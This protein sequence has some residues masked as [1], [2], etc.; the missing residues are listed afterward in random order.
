MNPSTA[1]SR[2]LVDELVRHGVAEAVVAPGSRSAPLAI[3]LADAA[4]RGRLRLHVRIDERSAAFTA[5]GLAKGAGVP[6]VVV[7]TSGTAVANMH[8]AVLE[9][10]HS[11][12]PL[13]ALTADRPAELRGAGANQTTDQVGVFGE[14]VRMFTDVPAAEQRSGQVA[15]WRSTV[16]RAVIAACGAVSGDPGP[17]HLNVCLREPLVPDDVRDAW[18]EAL[19]GRADGRPWTVVTG[20]RE[21]AGGSV[22]A[23]ARTV[24][25]IG[26]APAGVVDAA[27]ALGEQQRWPVVAEPQSRRLP[28]GVACGPLVVAAADWLDRHRPDRVLVVGRPTLSRP[29]AQ[30]VSGGVAPVDVVTTNPRWADA[31]G[32]A[33]TVYT[34]ADL[35]APEPS[36]SG[37]AKLLT[38]WTAA[39]E[40]AQA[41]V[42]RVLDESATGAQLP[43][44]LSAVRSCLRAVPSDALL[45][46]SSSSVVR[47][48]N[49][50]AERLP[51][52]VLTNRGVGGI[53]G[54][55]STAMG[56]AL[57]RG[58]GPAY[59]VMGDLA[60]LHDATGL[61]LGPDEARPDLCI[62]V[63]NDDGGGIFALLEQGAPRHA[64]T[65]E[66]VFG[67]PHGVDVEAL[68]AATHT[69]YQLAELDKLD[70]ALAPEPGLRVVEIRVDRRSHRE[71]HARLHEAVAA[72][73]TGSLPAASCR[74]A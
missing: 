45:F 36:G 6:A 1:L 37:D 52:T 54:T 25:V 5:L 30:L 66:R 11:G 20:R 38:A 64:A 72:A 70:A 59:A 40:R 32:G 48:A 16:S 19:D 15:Y 67:T 35:I 10:H 26:D 24:M 7:T 56:A 9:A 43:T 21:P 13:V 14:S 44:G 74:T 62:V 61:V 55:V 4:A 73:L 46:L 49:M 69:P 63:I 39:G 60:F 8:P 47:D 17:V 2:V 3:A 12:V 50:L 53:D 34:A 65:F 22:G 23:E 33:R 18:A 58:R 28:G 57:G 31:A 41:V 29:V 27:W 42:N 51:E 68:C 71:L